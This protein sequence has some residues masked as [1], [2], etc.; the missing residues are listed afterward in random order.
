MIPVDIFGQAQDVFVEHNGNGNNLFGL[1]DGLD[2]FLN[3]TS[4]VCVNTDDVDIGCYA[5]NDIN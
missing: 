1:L 2:E 5:C 4:S 3:C